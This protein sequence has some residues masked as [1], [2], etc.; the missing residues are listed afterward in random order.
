MV[1]YVGKNADIF[2]VYAAVAIDV[3]LHKTV[4]DLQTINPAKC[5]PLKVS[6]IA[7]ALLQHRANHTYSLTTSPMLSVTK[8][9]CMLRPSQETCELPVLSD[10]KCCN[11]CAPSNEIILLLIDLYN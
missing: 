11:C 9:K 10:S 7:V 4:K 6:A 1:G 8:V 5:I 2:L 3:E